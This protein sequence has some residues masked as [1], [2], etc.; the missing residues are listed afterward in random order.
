MITENSGGTYGSICVLDSG[1]QASDPFYHL[2]HPSFN[3]PVNI[4]RVAL[5][6]SS[7]V[8]AGWFTNPGINVTTLTDAATVNVA[9]SDGTTLLL[10]MTSAVGSNRTLTISNS[11]PGQKFTLLLQQPA[12]GGPCSVTWFSGIRWQGGSA[13]SLTTTANAIDRI[14]FE[15][16]STGVY[17]GTPHLHY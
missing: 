17:L 1:F 4:E 2:A 13:P 8:Q 10:P 3:W 12:S 6:N 16:L 9:A 14:D 11:L 7:R 15:T 5:L